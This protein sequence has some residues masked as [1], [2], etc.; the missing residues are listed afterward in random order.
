MGKKAFKKPER[1]QIQENLSEMNVIPSP[2]QF[3]FSSL[4]DNESKGT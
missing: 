4:V 3:Y 2:P 1:V